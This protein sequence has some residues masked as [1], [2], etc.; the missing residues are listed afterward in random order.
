M[1]RIFKNPKIPFMGLKYYFISFSLVLIILGFIAYFLRGGFNIGIDFAGGTQL[2]LKFQEK[3][4]LGKLRKILSENGF[5]EATIQEY[6][7]PELKEFLLRVPNLPGKEGETITVLQKVLTANLGRGEGFDLNLAGK[8]TFQLFLM[9]KFP[10]KE[11]EISY[12]AQS[13]SDYKKEKGVIKSVE[14]LKDLKGMKPEFY[15]HLKQNS[16]AG[17][18]SILNAESVG[19]KI[20]KDLQKKA[21]FAVIFSLL[22]MLVYIWFRFRH[23]AYGAGAVIALFHDVLIALA[24]LVFFNRAIDLTVIA[25]LLTLVGYSINDTVIVFDRIRENIRLRKG[26]T[27]EEIMNNSIN[28][29]LSRTIITSGLTFIVVACLFFLGGTVIHNFAFVLFVGIIIGTY[30]SIAIASPF[31]WALTKHK[32]DRKRR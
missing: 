31:A 20:G 2:T 7:E 4:D 5:G 1:I 14:E 3:P 18:F 25:A 26:T 27:L 9:E 21:T 15:L 32:F 24:F 16:F 11:E 23:F 19:P 28:E 22:G 30:S 8:S 29:T 17:P 12:L 10:E 6:D 13:F